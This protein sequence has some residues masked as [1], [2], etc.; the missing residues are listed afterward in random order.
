MTSSLILK[1]IEKMVNFSSIRGSRSTLGRVSHRARPDFPEPRLSGDVAPRARVL[2]QAGRGADQCRLLQHSEPH[3][4]HQRHTNRSRYHADNGRQTGGGRGCGV[5]LPPV[6]RA[7]QGRFH[8][9]LD[10]LIKLK[11]EVERIW[12]GPRQTTFYSVVCSRPGCGWTAS[13]VSLCQLNCPFCMECSSLTTR[14]PVWLR[15]SQ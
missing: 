15:N 1:R 14:S 9:L 12:E 7:N 2:S 4:L 6:M 8:H 13:S 5:S 11:T 3:N 10:E